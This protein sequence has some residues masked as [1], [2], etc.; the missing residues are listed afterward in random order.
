M[1]PTIT[2][3]PPT[4]P[5]TSSL[6]SKLD[7]FVYTTPV[8][9]YA[10]PPPS[11]TSLLSIMVFAPPPDVQVPPTGHHTTDSVLLS[12]RVFHLCCCI[13]GFFFNF[14]IIMFCAGFSLFTIFGYYL[15]VETF[16]FEDCYSLMTDHVLIS[17]V[18]PPSSTVPSGCCCYQIGI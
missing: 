17:T 15:V 3:A 1:P 2:Y 6:P 7:L 18:P 13:L 12:H 8:R 10:T 16:T 11:L 9:Q 4:L 14:I 5:H